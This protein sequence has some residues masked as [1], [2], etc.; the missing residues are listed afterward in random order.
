MERKK[1]AQKDVTMLTT[2][3]EAVFVETGWENREGN[4]VKKPES[5]YYYCGRLGGVDLSDQLLNYYSFLRKSMKWSRKLLIRLFNL[6]ILNVYI[7]N[8]HYGCQ[9]LT[10]DEFRDHLVKYLVDEGLKSY[11]I[12]LPPPP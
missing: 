4:R 8:K 3:H 12:P 9:K 1:G 11:K 6:V 2:I 10:H 5:V 7:L